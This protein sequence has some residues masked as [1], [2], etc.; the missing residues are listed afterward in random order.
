MN[1]RL[2]QL[3]LFDFW[4]KRL[5]EEESTRFQSELEASP[6]L[7]K[8]LDD[9]RDLFSAL[10]TLS[11]QKFEADARFT[12][13]IMRKARH[14]EPRRLYSVT[15]LF[16]YSGAI[17]A[18]VVLLAI[19]LE[20][21][22]SQHSAL[23]PST[24][25]ATRYNDMR[26]ASSINA[27]LTYLEGSAGALI[28]LLSTFLAF[29]CVFS[30]RW[31]TSAGFLTLA[32]ACFISRSFLT[33]FFNDH[34][35]SND[36][37]PNPSPS[38]QV[39]YN[40]ARLARGPSTLLDFLG[41]GSSS[42]SAGQAVLNVPAKPLAGVY[43]VP[44]APVPYEYPPQ[45]EERE[46]YAEY[47]ENPRLD[48]RA[49]PISTFSIDVDTASYSNARRF[50]SMG[51]MP[52]SKSVRVEEFLNYFDYEL[53]SSREAPFTLTYEIAPSPLQAGRHLLRLGLKAR[54]HIE[55]DKGWN[56]VFLVDVSGSMSDSDKLP[57]VKESLKLLTQRL[58]PQDRIS[59]VTYA[60]NAGLILDSTSGA[61]RERILSAIDSLYAGGSTNGSGGIELA[62]RIAQANRIPG[63]V[64]RVLLATDG[65][66]NI[67]VSSFDGL[68]R[69]IEEK[70]RSGITLT[71]LGF[72]RG[73]LQ[74][75]NMEQLADRGNGNYFYIDSF[76]EARKVLD[77]GMVSN[78]ETIAKDVKLQIE[79]NPAVVKQYRLIGFDNRKLKR[80]DFA[81]DAKDAGDIGAG[82]SVTA[83]YELVLNNS[84]IA[85][86]LDAEL[87]YQ[88]KAERPAAESMS[89]EVGFLKIRYK[90]PE[91][92]VSQ[93]LK[94]PLS[95]AAIKTSVE[96]ASTDFRFAA[97]V[98]YFGEILRNGQY[99][100]DYRLADVIRL[101]QSGRGNDNS[102]L[103]SE[104]IKLVQDAAAISRR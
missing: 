60:G 65:D 5:K 53:E 24:G 52:P 39:R 46:G 22:P 61:Q 69:L 62:Y 59:I 83:L 99:A 36:P 26:V 30:R 49:D 12:Q 67:G 29:V 63:S 96:E 42:S 21:T 66:F 75:Q 16:T 101:A 74:E 41:F 86:E 78:L 77:T 48:A 35:I 13:E 98:A 94:L 3:L 88:E 89:D 72:G 20:S 91:A 93:L 103:R 95:A 68:M 64:N 17:A 1:E 71:T 4:R 10:T 45:L 37:W 100:T 79:F 97:A 38:L 70:R 90:D 34:N 27:F 81:N 55:T 102:G 73:N 6:G 84:P 23:A 25:L 28:M 47:E 9:S 15:K 104:F 31:K 33:T 58:R 76:R 92:S 8:E 87:R 57:L 7:R 85:A 80:E 44:Q 43:S 82:H 50:L 54:P 2:R 18:A 32:M 19:G 11:E 14:T 40:D 56:L 51:Q